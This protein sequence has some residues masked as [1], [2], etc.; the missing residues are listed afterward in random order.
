MSTFPNTVSAFGNWQVLTRETRIRKGGK[1]II[2][3]A[4]ANTYSISKLLLDKSEAEVIRGGAYIKER[5]RLLDGATGGSYTPGQQRTTTR[6]NT[7]KEI[8]MPYR[9]YEDSIPWTDAEIDLNEGDQFAQWES[10]ENSI[11]QELEANHIKT[12][13][14][15]V[16]KVP[17]AATMESG[18]TSS[19]TAAVP[20]DAYSIPALITEDGLVAPTSTAGGAWTTIHG[21]NPSTYS[22]WKNQVAT[23]G[24]DLGAANTGLFAAFDRAFL[25]SEFMVPVGAKHFEKDDMA[26]LWI[27]T[28]LDGVNQFQ[29][30]LRSANDF[31][32]AGAQDPSYAGPQF[33]GKE[34]NYIAA[35]G[36]GSSDT[37]NSPSLLEQNPIGT[38]TGHVYPTGRPRYFGINTKYVFPCFHPKHFMTDKDKDGGSVQPDTT[39]RFRNSWFN[40]VARSRKRHF[41]IR[42]AA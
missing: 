26:K 42:P 22:N 16:W 9:F 1:D 25:L 17:N 10:F 33:K 29:S 7:L 15:S 19:T 23:Y 39:T 36:D 38:Y 28:N 40:I 37:N 34:I 27:A 5:I 14:S 11:D 2:N 12:L 4:C 13:E 35:L 31:T 30:L 20:G 24:T 3:D 8:S 6:V 21:Q 32:R 18:V 41:I